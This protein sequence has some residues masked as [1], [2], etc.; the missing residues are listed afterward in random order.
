MSRELV[1]VIDFGGQ[2]S[3]LI[4]RRIREESVYCE[5]HPYT[6]SVEKIQELSPKAIILSGGPSSVYLDESPDIDSEI[7]ELGIPVLGICYGMQIMAKKSGGKVVRA[8]KREYGKA[9]FEVLN[10]NHLTEGLSGELLVWMSHGDSVEELP[11]GFKVMGKTDNTPVAG[12]F[13]PQKQLYGVQFHLEVLHTPK[14]QE[15]LNNF[16]FEIAELS[17]DWTMDSYIDETVNSIKKEVGD[18]N[19][20]C[21]L[22][23][24]IDSTV[25]AV[26]VQQA[27]GDNLT[28]IFVNHGLL[29]KDEEN[30]VLELFRE[31]FDVKVVYVDARERFLSKLKGVTDP[32]QKRKIIGEEF[33]RVFEEEARKIGDVDFLVQGTLYTDVVES[34]TETASVIKSHHNVGG[35]PE[36]MELS[37]IEPLNSLFKDEVRQVAKELEMPK[38]VVW[39]HPFPGPGLAIRVLGEVTEDKLSILKEADA[40]VA[41]ELKKVGL[42]HDIWQLFTVLPDIKTVG[43]KGDERSYDY[44]I[45]LRAVNSQDG[46]TADWYRFSN[47][48]LESLS[49]RVVNEVEG[50]NRLVYDITSKPPATIEWE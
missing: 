6:I 39:R 45:I 3:Q 8:E 14:G 49:N 30:Q 20:I 29:R 37:L 5:I 44:P 21:G 28:C 12:I 32:E 23:G 38:E 46:M 13:N 18:R 11:P 26:L 48:V 25:A 34:G 36:K 43:V 40:V 10:G 22:S 7:F 27:I 47:D 33:I 4:A 2:Y 15:M 16:L 35:L 50:V 24:G 17:S 31:K 1:V 42:Y 19:A 9:L 41:D